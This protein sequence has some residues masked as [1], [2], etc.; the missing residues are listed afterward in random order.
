MVHCI[1]L[2]FFSLENFPTF[3]TGNSWSVQVAAICSGIYR[4]TFLYLLSC[5][6]NFFIP[7]F[8][9][10]FILYN[11]VFLKSGINKSDRMADD[12]SMS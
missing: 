10:I 8:V 1:T 5:P 7:F 4:C 2:L 9:E 12:N 3:F 6:Y 11:I